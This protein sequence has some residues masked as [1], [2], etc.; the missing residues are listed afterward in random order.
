[1]PNPDL[2]GHFCESPLRHCAPQILCCRINQPTFLLQSDS[3]K[4]A[5]RFKMENVQSPSSNGYRP[6]RIWIPLILL[7]FMGL[8]KFVADWVEDGPSMIWMV[9]AFGPMVGGLIIVIWWLT[10]SRARW[11]E[12]LAGLLGIFL[13]IVATAILVDST[14]QGP[15]LV[16]I[17]IPMCLAGFAIGACLFFRVL[18]FRRTILCLIMALLGASYSLLV[19]NYGTL[20]D[21]SFDL[22]WRW[23]ESPEQQF[24]AERTTRT[25]AVAESSQITLDDLATVQWPGFRGPERNGVQ[26]QSAISADGP[27]ELV[28]LWRIKVGP[29]W[30]SFAAAGDFLFT[31]EQRGDAETVVCYQA[32]SGKEVWASEIQSRFFEGLGGLGPR[33]TPTL[34]AGKIY[35]M[36]AEGFL[37]CLDATNGRELWKEDLR[38]I[39]KVD[40]PMWGFSSS[41]LVS[42][43]LAVV[44]AGG[45][46]DFGVVAFDA[47][48]G[49]LRWSARCG[50]QS[51]GS[52]Q[53]MQLEGKNYFAILS[54]EGAHFFEPSTGEVKLGYK[55]Q[56]SGYRALQPQL[57]DGNKLLIPTG[58]GSGTRLVELK[59][60][61]AGLEGTELWTSR[62]MKSD[63]NDLVVHQGYAYGFD[64]QIFACVD[65]QSGERQWKKGRYGKGQVLL[66]PEQGL[67]V[68]VGEKG[69]LVLLKT[70]PEEHEEV[71]SLQAFEGKTWNHPLVLGDRIYLRNAEEAIAYQ[72]R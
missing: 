55:W 48:S 3:P 35:A 22:D 52:V 25:D 26:I 12:R 68:V 42:N 49:Q 8:A 58:M 33:A 66:L 36:G 14:M 72:V 61:D 2:C 39:A 43:G 60:A 69:Q 9:P 63:F 13:I 34:A 7:T 46:D 64:S 11:T 10:V 62:E 20:G 44:H 53:E 5:K 4:T 15:P 59:Q 65:L 38:T 28:E 1:M 51:Y 32:S 37:R 30:S 31:Q 57:I 6:L 50:K 19:R 67:L 56:H 18:S 71:F 16:V 17:A 47:E 54:D 24:L 45:S 23:L 21:F 41:P 29:G 27:W 40:I 70:N